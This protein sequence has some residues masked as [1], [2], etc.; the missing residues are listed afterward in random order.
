M[1]PCQQSRTIRLIICFAIFFDQKNK[2]RYKSIF[3]NNLS[4]NSIE[5]SYKSMNSI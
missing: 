4:E 1:N 5:Y 2:I 3:Y